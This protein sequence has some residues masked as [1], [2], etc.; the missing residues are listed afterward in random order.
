M[1]PDTLVALTATAPMDFPP[2][3]QFRYNNTGYVILGMLIE[4][5]T[6]RK[7]ADDV[8]ERFAIPLGLPDT[9]WCDVKPVIA[10]RARGYEPEGKGFRNADFLAM[11]QPF[12]A[13]ALCST[14]ADLAKWNALLHGG[15]VVSSASYGA[16]TTP[17]GAARA[18]KTRYGF[19]LVP[20]TVVGPMMIQHGGGINGFL[21]ENAWFPESRTSVTVL[22]NSGSGNPGTLMR[23]VAR[24][25][26]GIPLLQPPAR[27]TLSA[28]ERAR[29]VGDY[30]LA[31][32]GG[33]RVFHVTEKDDALFGKLE[34]PGQGNFELVP[35]P[36]HTFGTDVDP[37]IRLVFT[38]ENGKAN[39]FTLQQG[40]G[41]MKAVRKG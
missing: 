15:K 9:R 17:E 21:S 39:G 6:G 32:P 7:W 25:A 37:D 16:M 33:A 41:T 29:Y 38:V 34:G 20:D 14:V 8:Q 26:L 22:T 2:G 35:Y 18:G 13:G 27:I 23:Q 31:L 3:S 12:S 10:R 1:P 4:K 19:G 5:L 36:N 30:D 28:A 24:T 11:S 40:G